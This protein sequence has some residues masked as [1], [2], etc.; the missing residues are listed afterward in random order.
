MITWPW[1]DSLRSSIPLQ[2]C[3]ATGFKM[4]TC[5]ILQLCGHLLQHPAGKPLGCLSCGWFRPILMDWA[6]PLP[7]V[8]LALPTLYWSSQ[9]PAVAIVETTSCST[10]S[11]S[12]DVTCKT[13]AVYSKGTRMDKRYRPLFQQMLCCSKT[14]WRCCSVVKQCPD[15]RIVDACNV[16]LSQKVSWAIP[17]QLPSWLHWHILHRWLWHRL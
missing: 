9:S 7:T 8:F 11:P 16:V 10:A 1:T 14:L 17:W 12:F 15:R 3:I 6:C 5:I 2:R 13:H 4:R